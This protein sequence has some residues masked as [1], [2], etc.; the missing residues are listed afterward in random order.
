MIL[1]QDHRDLF[2]EYPRFDGRVV[3]L[4]S[5]RSRREHLCGGRL[6]GSREVAESFVAPLFENPK[7]G[8]RYSTRSPIGSPR[9]QNIGSVLR[10]IDLSELS[11][12]QMRSR[13]DQP[14]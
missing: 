1:H 8:T 2:R 9:G 3:T 11:S 14:P 7:R 12:R 4:T 13:I 5:P 6:T 10:C